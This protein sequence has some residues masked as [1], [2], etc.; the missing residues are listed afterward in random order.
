MF[1]ADFRNVLHTL[2]LF[3][4]SRWFYS[5]LRLQCL[6][7]LLLVVSLMG[8]GGDQMSVTDREAAIEERQQEIETLKN[9]PK[10]NP[11]V[12]RDLIERSQLELDELQAGSTGKE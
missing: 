7:I 12:K 6:L 4:F 10:M 3:H 5:M 11:Q 8:C 1:L 9:D 2:R